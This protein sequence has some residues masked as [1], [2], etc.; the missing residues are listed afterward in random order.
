MRRSTLSLMCLVAMLVLGRAAPMAT[1][2]DHAKANAT[3]S[4]GQWQTDP[5]LDRFRVNFAN[6]AVKRITRPMLGFKSFDAARHTLS[7]ITLMHM[8]RKSQWAGGAEQ[9]LTAAEQFYA[10]AA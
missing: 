7:G 2:G 5:P 9:G 1:V 4:F 10:L 6:R 3:V 8:L